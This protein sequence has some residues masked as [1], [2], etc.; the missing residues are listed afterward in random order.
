MS[1]D[2][3]RLFDSVQ[4]DD[5]GDWEEEPLTSRDPDDEEETLESPMTEPATHLALEKEAEEKDIKLSTKLVLQDG[6]GRILVLKDAYS[7]FWDLPGG[8]VGDGEKI[9]ESL[10]REVKEEVGVDVNEEDV[11]E[12]FVREIKLGKETKPVTFFYQLV[13]VVPDVSLSEEHEEFKWADRE[14]LTDLNLGVF[15]EM[16]EEAEEVIEKADIPRTLEGPV[17]RKLYG[18]KKQAVAI[19]S[20]PFEAPGA[21]GAM[22]KARPGLVPKKV[23]VRRGGKTF[24]A[25][26]WIKPEQVEQIDENDYQEKLDY[27]RSIL[28][29][30]VVTDEEMKRVYNT[31]EKAA[32]TLPEEHLRIV[33]RLAV[34]D[35]QDKDFWE[36]D[37]IGRTFKNPDNITARISIASNQGFATLAHEIAHGLEIAGDDK[38]Q[39]FL[40][41]VNEHWAILRTMKNYAGFPTKYSWEN[42]SEFFCECY[43]FFWRQ[44]NAFKKRN[45]YM[46]S[47]LKKE[48]GND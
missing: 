3:Q 32:K 7:N 37:I 24:Q 5:E 30:G 18:K 35:Y 19:S 39:K 13:E 28:H 4:Y 41:K 14:E 9:V 42:P 45:P 43:Q 6:E 12:L 8:H 15:H 23:R 47:L 46:H 44:P 48:F 17:D 21:F 1:K 11:E 38:F 36:R 22:V 16:L 31:L 34:H 25:I 27:L 29:E 2:L 33:T 10:I 20:L 40:N 26:R